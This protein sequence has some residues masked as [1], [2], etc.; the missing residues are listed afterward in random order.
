MLD[1]DK[2][3]EREMILNRLRELDQEIAESELRLRELKKQQA[4]RLPREKQLAFYTNEY[5]RSDK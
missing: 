3:R 2:T 5:L 1:P 4:A